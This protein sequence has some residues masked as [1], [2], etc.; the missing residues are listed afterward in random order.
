[1]YTKTSSNNYL[2]AI[3]TFLS[4]FYQSI[5]WGYRNKSKDSVV[6]CDVCILDDAGSSSHLVQN[7]Q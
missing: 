5:K 7:W 3:I 1:M 2:N 6:I 4:S